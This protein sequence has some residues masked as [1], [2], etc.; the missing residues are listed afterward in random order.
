MFP[1]LSLRASRLALATASLLLPVT[2][3]TVPAGATP[4]PAATGIDL[5]AEVGYDAGF[6]GD[7]LVTAIAVGMAESSC[8]PLASN[9]QN[10]TP[11]SRD[12]GLWE[13]NDYW[14]PE[15]SDA[16]AFD[17]QCNANAAYRI[18][19]GGTNWQPW[20]TYNQGAH[21]R[22]L[23]AAQAA[24][25]RLGHHDPGPAPLVYP[26]KSGRV[27][28][29][30]SADGRLEVFAAGANGVSHAWQTAVN[31]AWSDW[32]SLGGP[33]GAQLAIGPDADGR[34]EVFALNGSTL[35]HRYQLQPSGTWSNWETFGGGGHDLA[36]GANQDGRLEVFASGPA[37][38]FHKYQTAP[39][40]G[41]SD[42]ETAGGGPADSEVRLGKAPDGRLEVFALNSGTFQHQWQTAVN[43]GWSNWET[44]GGGGHA[45]TVDHNQD[46]RLEVL[47]SGPAGI[48]HKY[49]TSPT[50]W[51]D[52]EAAGGPADS[53]ISSERSPDGRVEAFAINGTT[54]Q[55]IWQTGVNA[56]YGQWD[57][58][59]G[60][61]TEIFATA[62][63]DGRIEVFGASS[64]GVYHKWQ[65]G[66]STWSDWAWLNTTAGPA[67]N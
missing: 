33:G 58:F 16:C 9:V 5:C 32:E 46:G 14:H 45:L 59:G 6:R 38:I 11:P 57:T 17:A 60:G 19:N 64:A 40:S 4:A 65:T 41:W 37:G 20:S 63:A 67:V 24:A 44:F 50:G 10:N 48:F 15:V 3:P 53:R 35:Q 22:Y 12:R 36:V 18:S 55:H 2:V 34:L 51:S 49:Q 25:D 29:T 7:A 23:S 62:D 27:V 39:N 8:D 31:G 30:R 56:S 28:S 26:A 42:W 43:G 54:A 61:G 21:Q 47:A 13:I 52:W 66:F 1:S